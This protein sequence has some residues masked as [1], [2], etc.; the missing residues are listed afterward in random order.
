M[1]KSINTVT[2]LNLDERIA[3]S[4]GHQHLGPTGPERRDGSAVPGPTVPLAT[5]HTLAAGTSALTPA[6]FRDRKTCRLIDLL[7][8]GTRSGGVCALFHR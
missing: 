8:I 7:Q 4:L 3:P 5:K 1:C 2:P 6:S